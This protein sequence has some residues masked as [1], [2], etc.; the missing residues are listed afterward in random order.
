ML[1]LV[2]AASF[3]HFRASNKIPYIPG[4]VQIFSAVF[5]ILSVV[6]TDDCYNCSL[7]YYYFQYRFLTRRCS[8]FRLHRS[9]P[10]AN[11]MHRHV[12]AH[13]PRQIACVGFILFYRVRL[14]VFLSRDTGRNRAFQQHFKTF[15]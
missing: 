5:N 15:L 3:N 1:L 7:Y 4:K 6:L 9:S 14:R 2:A 10:K 11:W 12:A 13:T 8:I